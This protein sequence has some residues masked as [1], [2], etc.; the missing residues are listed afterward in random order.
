MP[1]MTYFMQ[2]WPILGPYDLLKGPLYY[3]ESTLNGLYSLKSLH[4]LVVPEKG[5]ISIFL[6]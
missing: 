4:E 1:K 6:K 5:Y 3:Q 2:F